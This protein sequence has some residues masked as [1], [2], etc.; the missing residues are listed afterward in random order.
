MEGGGSSGSYSD[1]QEDWLTAF[2]S[3]GGF[4]R[5][6]VEVPEYYLEDNLALY[7]L[8]P[9]IKHFSEAL[10]LIRNEPQ[11]TDIDEMAVSKAAALLYAHIHARYVLTPQGLEDVRQ[12]YERCEYGK[13]PR[14]LCGGQRLLPYSA[15]EKPGK[16]VLRC[17]CPACHKLYKLYSMDPEFFIDG[18]FYGPSLVPMFILTY[19]NILPP[20]SQPYEPTLYGF[21]L[22]SKQSRGKNIHPAISFLKS[23]D[24]YFAKLMDTRYMD[25]SE[26]ESK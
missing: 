2:L 14:Y 7:G 25:Y 13:C 22:F 19:P 9:E 6:L 3:Q 11:T 8:E 18:C 10:K 4:R 1:E 12:K 24:P 20:Q 16:D 5:L 26:L 15:T 23:K 17:F 21:K